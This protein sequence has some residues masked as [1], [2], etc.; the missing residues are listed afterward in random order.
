MWSVCLRCFFL[1]FSLMILPEIK[2]EKEVDPLMF[3]W[4]K[5]REEFQHWKRIC[6]ICR[7]SPTK[8]RGFRSFQV[9]R[10]FLNFF[11]KQQTKKKGGGVKADLNILGMYSKELSLEAYFPLEKGCFLSDGNSILHALTS[12]FCLIGRPQPSKGQLCVRSR[13]GA[14]AKATVS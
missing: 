11:Q 10:D 5:T 9:F 14:R 6:S 2:L 3:W 12:P 7:I 1:F 13:A 8:Q 4:R